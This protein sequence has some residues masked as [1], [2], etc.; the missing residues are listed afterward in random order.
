MKVIDLGRALED[1]M[2]VFPGDD[3]PVVERLDSCGFQVTD[4]AGRGGVCGQRRAVLCG[5]RR[6]AA[7][8][9]PA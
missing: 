7:V 4:G 2:Q 6:A 1:S 3:A 5:E 9:V 8:R